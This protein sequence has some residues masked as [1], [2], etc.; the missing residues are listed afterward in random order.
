MN[1][2]STPI[3]VMGGTFDPVHYGHLHPA[4]EV[5]D[6]VGME[7][8]RFVPSRV[9]VHRDQPVATLAD[10]VRWL[11]MAAAEFPQFVVDMREVERDSPSWMVLTLESMA[12]EFPYSPLCLIMGMDAFLK[13]DSWHRWGD[14]FEYAHIV[15]THRPGFDR[16]STD[17]ANQLLDGR[18]AEKMDELYVLPRAAGGKIFFYPV[19]PLEISATE[20]RKNIRNGG[21]SASMVPE[22]IRDE[23]DHCYRDN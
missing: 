13:L 12:H 10:R 18:E 1:S 23:V 3:G 15:V 2:V 16:P 5:C 20:I 8:I 22:S 11:Q 19:T 9:P 6:G 17:K 14:L 21:S 7:Q 4:A